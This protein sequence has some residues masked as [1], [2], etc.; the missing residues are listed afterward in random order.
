MRRPAMVQDEI[1]LRMIEK[2]VPSA[3][4][5]ALLQGVVE[6]RPILAFG[7]KGYRDHLFVVCLE[8]VY[9]WMLEAQAEQA[10]IAKASRNQ[11]ALFDAPKPIEPEEERE[12]A[13]AEIGGY[14]SQVEPPAKPPAPEPEEEFRFAR[15]FQVRHWPTGLLI[16][17]PAPAGLPK[18]FTSY[19]RQTASEAAKAAT[20]MLT[21]RFD[22]SMLEAAL[23]E[24]PNHTE[25]AA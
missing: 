23:D 4:R 20:A 18:D 6:L 12:P 13:W 19:C 1:T 3:R 2:E 21:R 15:Q 14:R 7:V 25:S 22:L 5:V 11:S 9:D 17:L 8:P 24:L 10:A 16:A